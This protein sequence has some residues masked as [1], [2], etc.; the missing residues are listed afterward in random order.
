MRQKG[1]EGPDGGRRAGVRPPAGDFYVRALGMEEV[2]F[3]VEVASYA[4]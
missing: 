4:R 1:P 3:L 2:T